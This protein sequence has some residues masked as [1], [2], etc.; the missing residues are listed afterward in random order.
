MGAPLA[1]SL[2]A[3][4]MAAFSGTQHQNTSQGYLDGESGFPYQPGPSTRTHLKTTK[5]DT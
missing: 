4:N 3:A 1:D 5:K 2:S